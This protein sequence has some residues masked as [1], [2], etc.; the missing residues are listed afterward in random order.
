MPLQ[1]ARREFLAGMAAL[2]AAKASSGFALPSDSSSPFRVAVINDEIS[3]DF[4]R[5]CEV[6]AREFGMGWIELRG[7][8]KKNI[9][10][11]DE[12]EVA[13]ARR[14]LD[15]YQLK[16]TDIASPLFKV[17]W[18]GAPKSKFSEA[19]SFGANFT[20]AQQDEVLER[21]MD[22]AKAFQTDRVRCF[23][24]W[25]LEDQTPYRSAIDDKLRE[26]AGKVQKKGMTLVLEN[27]MACNTATAVESSRVL[28]AVQTPSFMLNWDP[29]NAAASGDTPYPDGYNLLPKDRIGHCHCKDV[30]KTGKSDWAPMGGGVID[31]AG[32]FKALKRDGFHFAVSLE[33]HWSGGGSPEESSRRSW[34][35]MKKLLQQAQAL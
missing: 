27:E 1:L 14:I 17:D 33:T 15:K 21:A 4:G 31:W 18:P 6:A 23:D 28:S 16:V 25:R 32:Q 24:F 20:L 35:G 5:A 19:N 13:E 9:V 10:S 26:A 7:M 29:G 34:A 3:Q 2:T 11:L 30:V 8:W 22:M 12:K